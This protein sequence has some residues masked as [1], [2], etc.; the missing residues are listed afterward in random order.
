[1]GRHALAFNLDLPA[2]RHFGLITAGIGSM[3][4]SIINLHR[5]ECLA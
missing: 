4:L 3:A 5:E 1:M 2:H